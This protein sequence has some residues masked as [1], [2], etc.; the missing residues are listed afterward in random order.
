MEEADTSKP[1][2]VLMTGN[3]AALNRLA[4]LEASR[5]AISASTRVRSTS[6]GVQRCV[7]AVN[8]TSGAVRRTVASLSRRNHRRRADL[9][10]SDGSGANTSRSTSRRSSGTAQISECSAALTS[11]HHVAAAALAAAMLTGTLPAAAYI[12]T[13]VTMLFT[14]LS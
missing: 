12:P 8:R 14:V 9:R 11:T 4:V 1:S 5:A 7:L 6:S 10:R 13:A 3:A 2:R